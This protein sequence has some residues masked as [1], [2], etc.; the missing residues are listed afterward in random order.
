MKQDK[1]IVKIPLNETEYKET[2]FKTQKEVCEF[3]DIKPNTLISLMSGRLQLVHSDKKK[4]KGIVIEKIPLNTT[5]NKPSDEELKQI[6]EE[7]KKGLLDKI[8]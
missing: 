8:S 4:L 7:Y 1:F 2:R 3:L 5:R 6:E